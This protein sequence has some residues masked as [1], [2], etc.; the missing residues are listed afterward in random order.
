[1]KR[2]IYCGRFV[3]WQGIASTEIIPEF[4]PPYDSDIPYCEGETLYQCYKCYE[5]EIPQGIK[6]QIKRVVSYFEKR[7]A[8]ESE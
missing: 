3:G 6:E 1:M 8:G 2:C 7:C 5:K 4:H